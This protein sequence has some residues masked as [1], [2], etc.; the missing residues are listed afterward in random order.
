MIKDRIQSEQKN[1]VCG[2]ER[3][4]EEANWTSEAGD[5]FDQI[6][7]LRISLYSVWIYILTDI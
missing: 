2:D 5:L 1:S 4:K 7:E 6:F 3:R